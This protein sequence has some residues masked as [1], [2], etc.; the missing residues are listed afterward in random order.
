MF[1]WFIWGSVIFAMD[2]A[3]TLLVSMRLCLHG[4]IS[5]TGFIVENKTTQ[6]E[7][8]ASQVGEQRR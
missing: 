1:S 8:C 3:L 5:T 7:L 6:L 2:I 4:K